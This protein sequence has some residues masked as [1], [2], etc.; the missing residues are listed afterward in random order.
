MSILTHPLWPELRPYVHI[1]VYGRD[2]GPDNPRHRI[3]V[4]TPDSGVVLRRLLA[5]TMPCVV[6]Q[7]PIHPVRTRR[8]GPLY[9]AATCSLDVSYACARS[10]EARTEYDAV[11][12]AMTA[13]HAEHRPG[14]LD[15]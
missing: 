3:D 12:R 14:L 6:C 15:A 10:A 5:I 9:Y 2:G 11:K 4:R 1:G 8:K 7:R 13:Y